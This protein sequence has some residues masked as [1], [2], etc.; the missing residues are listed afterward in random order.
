MNLFILVSYGRWLNLCDNGRNWGI[1]GLGKQLDEFRKKQRNWNE[2]DKI[3]TSNWKRK[4]NNSIPNGNRK[5]ENNPIPN[6]SRNTKVM[7]DFE[8]KKFPFL[9]TWGLLNLA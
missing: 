5:R 6:W 3:P 9:Y 8:R 1:K 7:D 2:L 4:E